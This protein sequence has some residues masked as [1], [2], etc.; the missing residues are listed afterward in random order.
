M[1]RSPTSQSV[2]IFTLKRLV[3]CVKRKITRIPHAGGCLPLKVPN[4]LGEAEAGF[5][6]QRNQS[7]AFHVDRKL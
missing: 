6:E 5:R 1:P 2:T 3:I 4:E 7:E